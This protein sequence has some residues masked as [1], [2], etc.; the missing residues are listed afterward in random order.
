M[1]WGL[2]GVFLSIPAIMAGP[3]GAQLPRTSPFFSPKSTCFPFLA[4]RPMTNGTL[5]AAKVRSAMLSTLF[6]LA[7]TILVMMLA[8]WVGGYGDYLGRTVRDLQKIAPGPRAIGAVVLGLMLALILTWRQLTSS[9]VAGLT[10]WKF[11]TDLG[12]WAFLG[13][14]TVVFGGGLWLSSH[15]RYVP[16]AKAAVPWVL[17]TYLVL[18]LAGSSWAFREASRRGFMTNREVLRV[19]AIWSAVV[20]TLLGLAAW[21]LPAKAL[22]VAAPVVWIALASMVPLGRIAMSPLALEWDRHR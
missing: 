8:L 1:L 14:A 5:V 20:A 16:Y 7:I 2:L 15:P 13:L 11:V 19:T 12:I 18:K 17:G 22:P 9:M 21:V 4:T 6:S 3:L 10:G